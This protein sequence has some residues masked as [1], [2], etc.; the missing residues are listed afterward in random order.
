ME[1]GEPLVGLPNLTQR[2]GD[3]VASATPSYTPLLRLL[4]LFP[5]PVPHALALHPKHTLLVCSHTSMAQ[6]CGVGT[7]ALRLSATGAGPVPVL[8]PN[9]FM[10][11]EAGALLK[12][13]SNISPQDQAPTSAVRKYYINQ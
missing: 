6:Q 13:T 5:C 10:T 4:L 8:P 3:A 11:P 9:M 1:A 2:V 7:M 12:Q